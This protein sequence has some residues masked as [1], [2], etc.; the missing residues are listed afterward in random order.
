MAHVCTAHLLDSSS[1]TPHVP[2]KFARQVKKAFSSE[3]S[4]L[5]LQCIIA[6][7]HTP[8]VTAIK[9]SEN[10][11]PCQL[12]Y[13]LRLRK[14]L[15][16][17]TLQQIKFL[18]TLKLVKFSKYSKTAWINE[19]TPKPWHIIPRPYKSDHSLQTMLILSQWDHSSS[20]YSILTNYDYLK[21]YLQYVPNTMCF[22]SAW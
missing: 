12:K 17:L 21:I 6:V 3:L 18:V 16:E 4:S 22:N 1:S 8:Y 15:W 2:P 20:R 14:W 5:S 10:S 11:G 9:D 13:E 7:H 19:A